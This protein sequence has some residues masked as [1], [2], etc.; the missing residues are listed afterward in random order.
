MNDTTTLRDTIV[1]QA[2]RVLDASAILGIQVHDINFGNLNRHPEI[3]VHG[4][5]IDEATGRALAAAVGGTDIAL[6][7]PYGHGPQAHLTARTP[8]FDFRVCVN[9]L[10]TP[11]RLAGVTVAELAA[12][13]ERRR[14]AAQAGG[15]TS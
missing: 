15:P 8:E 9:V 4:I 11:A 14:A 12:E 7:E 6:S 10:P 1:R 3:T 5:R 13:I 2:G